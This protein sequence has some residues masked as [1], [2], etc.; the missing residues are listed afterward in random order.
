MSNIEKPERDIKIPYVRFISSILY[1]FLG[2]KYPKKGDYNFSKVGLRALEVK[3]AD[4][5]VSLQTLRIRLSQ[6]S[7]SSVVTRMDSSSAIPATTTPQKR[8]S[9]ALTGPSKK[10]K[11]TVEQTPLDKVT[12]TPSEVTSIITSV[13]SSIPVTSPSISLV[14]NLPPL[15]QP[16]LNVAHVGPVVPQTSLPFPSFE[17]DLN[18]LNMFDTSGSTLGTVNA[19]VTKLADKLDSLVAS[20]NTN[21]TAVNTAG[22][23]LKTLYAAT[24]TKDEASQLSSLQTEVTALKENVANNSMQI[25]F[26]NGHVDHL[27]GEVKTLRG[28]WR[29]QIME[30][31]LQTTYAIPKIE[32]CLDKLETDARK[33]PVVDTAAATTTDLPH[34]DDK[35]GEKDLNEENSAEVQEIVEH[36]SHAEGEKVTEE[37]A[38]P[39]PSLV[40]VEE[41]GEEEDEELDLQDQEGNDDVITDDDEDEDPS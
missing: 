13:S 34:D 40:L 39:S 25:K 30:F 12:P 7:S 6:T 28:S 20:L 17:G 32:G 29:L 19:T 37:K 31:I 33:E 21:T 16:I 10:A 5:E 18:F 36:L 8:K 1:F 11:K 41:E 35:E 3:P 27:T 15:Q 26:L 4:N 2:N 24:S 38:P 22:E 9:T 14:S 23:E